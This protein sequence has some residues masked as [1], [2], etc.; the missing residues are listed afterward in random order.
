MINTIQLPKPCH[1]DWNAMEPNEQGRHCLAC[2]KTVV[3]FTNRE[4]EEIM[5]YLKANV[6]REVCGRFIPSQLDT[7][8]VTEE[9]TFHI[10]NSSLSYCKKIA[11]L[12]LIT[13]GILASSADKSFSQTVKRDT[14]QTTG[15]PVVDSSIS[16]MMVGEVMYAPSRKPIKKKPI[17]KTK[18]HVQKTPKDSIPMTGKVYIAPQPVLMGAV[19]VPDKINKAN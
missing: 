12:I 9:I 7:P 3:D 17:K 10:F 8:I 5:Q 6:G 16:P 4:P 2:C 18:C 15:A 19:E 11:A 1:Q 13:F 14:V